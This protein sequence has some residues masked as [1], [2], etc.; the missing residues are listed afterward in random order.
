MYD[1]QLGIKALCELDSSDICL[2]LDKFRTAHIVIPCA[3]L[4][5]RQITLCQNVYELLVLSVYRDH[6]AAGF[7]LFKYLVKYAVCYAEVVDH[8][9]L[10]R[11]YTVV[12]SVLYS[13]DKSV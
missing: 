7:C 2:A 9:Y 1:V 10:E 11:R 5:L 6:S 8:K 12:Y 3:C 4:A 13:V